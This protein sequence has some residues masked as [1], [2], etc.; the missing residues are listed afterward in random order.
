MTAVRS[1]VKREAYQH[2]IGSR[3]RDLVPRWRQHQPT[4][5]RVMVCVLGFRESSGSVLVWTLI[6]VKSSSDQRRKYV[7]TA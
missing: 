5:G 7:G 4:A 3:A 6:Y 2:L 1:G